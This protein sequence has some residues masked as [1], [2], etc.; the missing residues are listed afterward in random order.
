M[1][2]ALLPIIT[3]CTAFSFDQLSLNWLGIP[4]FF[5]AAEPNAI[6]GNSPCE[7]CDVD[8][9]H[10]LII[11]DIELEP[12]PPVPGENLTVVASGELLVDVVDGAYVDVVVSYGYIVLVNKRYDLCELLPEVDLECPVS[13]GFLALTKTVEIPAEVPPGE[14]TVQAKAY[15]ADETLL[16]CLTATVDI[17]V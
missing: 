1:I 3:V 17:D 2:A 15:N 4:S 11:K 5:D 9:G 13:K 12:Y 6:P 7:L 14:Y 8:E 10:H 16:S